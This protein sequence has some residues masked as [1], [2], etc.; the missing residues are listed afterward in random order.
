M[1]SNVNTNTSIFAVA[2]AGPKAVLSTIATTASVVEDVINDIAANRESV[3]ESIR[4]VGRSLDLGVLAITNGVRY[5]VSEAL[6]RQMTDE[7]WTTSSGR[8]KVMKEIFRYKPEENQPM[9]LPGKEEVKIEEPEEE[10]Y[11]IKLSPL[12]KSKNSMTF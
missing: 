5:G 11:E 2:A 10:G 9:E 6:G 12:W 4:D 1:Q 3:T 7:E 8:R